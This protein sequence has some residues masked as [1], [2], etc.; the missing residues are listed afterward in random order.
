MRIAVL[1][2]WK[3]DSREQLLQSHEEF[4]VACEEIGRELARQEQVVIVGGDSSSTADFHVAKGMASVM[5]V[6]PQCACRLEV[7]ATRDDRR[8][9]DDLFRRFPKHVSY[10]PVMGSRWAEVHLMQIKAADAVITIG[11]AGGTYQGGLAALVAKKLLV[12]IGTFGG[13]SSRLADILYKEPNAPQAELGT[14]RGAWCSHLLDTVVGLLGIGR[15]PRILLIHGRSDDRYKL[16]E[17][18]R[19]SL[20][21]DEILVMQQEFG[22]GLTLPEKFEGIGARVDGAIALAT[23]DDVVMLGGDGSSTPRARQNVWLEVGWVWGRL[24]RDKVMLLTKG[25]LENPSD[26]QGMEYYGYAADPREISEGIRSFVAGLP[27]SRHVR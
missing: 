14:L 13:A 19:G 5:A 8:L 26:I 4:A 1:G 9:F 17:F 21:L 11:G 3:P 25:K 10:P 24:G 16:M 27:R 20:G 12:P 7:M 2:S 15:K 18:L 22:G 6:M 23:P